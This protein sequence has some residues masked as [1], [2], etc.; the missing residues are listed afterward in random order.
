MPGPRSRLGAV[1]AIAD[2][3]LLS[4]ARLPEAVSEIAAAGIET[5]QLRLKD[6]SNDAD[7]YRAVA[8]TLRRLEGSAVALWM[9]DRADLAALFGLPGLHLGQRDLPPAAARTVVG[10]GCRLGLSTH[11]EDEVLAAE[12]DPEVDVVAIGPIFPTR[13]KL[14]P[15]PVLGLGAV[16]RAR[17]LTTKPLIAIGGIEA[18]NIAR[19]LAAGADSAAVAGAICRDASV[20]GGIGQNCRRL[21][22]SAV[23]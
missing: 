20:A 4:L 18:D 11:S 22:A 12:A 7:L 6:G 21:M 2:A 19:V 16:A 14:D 3:A 8:N 15:A 10:S 5:I 17:R 9:N 23:G 13:T 1:Y